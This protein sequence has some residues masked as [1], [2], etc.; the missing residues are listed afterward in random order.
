MDLKKILKGFIKELIIP[1]IQGITIGLVFNLVVGFTTVSGT[2]MYP[3]LNHGDFL[4][5]S[6][7]SKNNIKNEDIVVF[8]TTPE[9]GYRDKIYYVKRIIGK[10]GDHVVI[11][12]SEVIVNGIKM[13]ERYTDGSLTE[14][15]FDIKVPD[16]NYFVLGDNRDESSDSRYFGLV[17]HD[18]IVGV[19]KMRLYPFKQIND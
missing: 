3:T 11:K 1:C 9:L 4:A 17:S 14:G 7:L 19:V 12:D 15:E 13:D 2:S 6:K 5:L 10:P 18:S 8:D 16:G